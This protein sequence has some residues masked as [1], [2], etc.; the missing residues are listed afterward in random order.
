MSEDIKMGLRPKRKPKYQHSDVIKSFMQ[1]EDPENA[2]YSR[3]NYVK[4]HAASHVQEY[5]SPAV[6]LNQNAK[7]LV[8][9]INKSNKGSQS[10]IQIYGNIAMLRKA[11][12][13]KW[14]K[15]MW[16]QRTRC[17]TKTQNH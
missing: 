8:K 10:N 13:N 9:F 1:E 15:R 5:T 11:S 16:F 4:F 12:K 3:P 2:S 7:L 17:W 6:Q 14:R